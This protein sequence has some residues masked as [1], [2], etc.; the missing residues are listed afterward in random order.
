LSALEKTN[1]SAT[2][3]TT[4]AALQGLVDNITQ[5]L[6]GISSAAENNTAVTNALTP[7]I[8]SAAGVTGVSNDN[9]ALI[10]QML[11]TA[12]ING[13]AV[14][15]PAK[16]QALV[17]AVQKIRALADGIDGT[18][19]PLDN[20]DITALGLSQVIRLEADRGLFNDILDHSASSS[21]DSAA[22]I[23]N[24]ASI[25]Q[26]VVQIGL[27]D[28]PAAALTSQDFQAAGLTGVTSANL[29]RVLAAIDT[30][31]IGT[32]ARTVDTLAELQTLVNTVNWLASTAPVTMAE[33]SQGVSAAELADGLQMVVQLPS[34]AGVG[35]LLSL[36]LT[37]PNGDQRWFTHTLTAQNLVDGSVSLTVPRANVDEDGHYT[38]TSSIK[39][40]V[41]ELSTAESV[42]TFSL[43]VTAPEL[44]VTFISGNAVS[45][46][47]TAAA[48]GEFSAAERFGNVATPTAAT[49]V[50][51]PVVLQGTTTAEL[52]QSL[53]IKLNDKT[54]LATVGAGASGQPNIWTVTLPEADAKSLNHAN[55][56]DVT[57]QVSDVASN[58]TIDNQYKLFVNTAYPDVPTVDN[59]YTHGVMQGASY[60]A[61]PVLTGKA[62]KLIVGALATD[63]NNYIALADA[64][65]ITFNINGQVVTGSV[66]AL[67]TNGLTYN[68]GTRAWSLDTNQVSGFNTLPD[69]TYD[70]S[71]TV[72]AG[73]VTMVDRGS[74]ELRILS[75]PPSLNIQTLA[76]DGLINKGET[77]LDLVVSGSTDAQV[78]APVSLILNGQTYNATV[79]AG[80]GADNVFS[81]TVPKAHVMGWPDGAASVQ[82]SVT[83]RYGATT[84]LSPSLTVDTRAPGQ[85]ADGTDE[86]IAFP[87]VVLTENVNATAGI[88]AA[89]LT[90]GMQAQVTLPTGSVVGDELEIAVT[91]PN[92]T[93]RVFSHTLIQAD[94]TSGTATVTLSTSA[95]A[96]NG[97]YAVTAKTTDVAGNA[98]KASAPLSFTLDTLAPGQNAD[99]S[100]GTIP[101]TV[102]TLDEA[103]N[104]IN[105]TEL[106][107]GL[108]YQ[109]QLPTGSKAGDT[110]TFSFTGPDNTVRTHSHT[111]TAENVAAGTFILSLPNT[112]VNQDGTYTVTVRSTDTAGNAGNLATT[113]FDLTAALS[114]LRDAA[115]GNTAN[116]TTPALDVYA[117]AGITG[118]DANNLDEINSV[119]NSAAVD[120]TATNSV[121]KVQAIV[122]AYNKVLASANGTDGDATNAVSAIE[123]T[124]LGVT[125]VDSATAA[126]LSDVVD[127]K[128]SGDVDTVAELQALADAAKAAIT[129]T[130]AHGQ[131][132]PTLAQIN[133]LVAG[134][135]PGGSAVPV[136]TGD[137]AAAVQAA[138]AAANADGTAVTTQAEL[139]NIVKAAVSDYETAIAKIAAYA[140]AA[141]DVPA[142]ADYAAAGITGVTGAVGNPA[143]GNLDAINSAIKAQ[144]GVDATDGN[145]DD[146][147]AANSAAKVQAIVNAYTAILSEANG[148]A[149]D[150]NTASNP[151]A[152]QYAAI[153][154][155]IGAAATDAENLALLNSIVGAKTTTGV[156][157]IAE[158]NTLASLA[159]AIQTQAAGGTPTPL[160]TEVNLASL[161][162]TGVTTDNLRAVLNAIAAQPDSGTDTDSL[163]KLQ[164]VIGSAV[165]AYQSALTAIQNAAQNNNATDT[166]PTAAQYAALGV[167]GVTAQNL[168]AMNSALNDLDI[169]GLQANT[170][171]KV[172]TLVDAYRVILSTA[173]GAPN[174]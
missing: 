117:K 167:S 118:V 9:V 139:A 28:S 38:L 154:A 124:V 2:P 55:T 137:N 157:T 142:A 163:S 13:N 84:Q 48:T 70:V 7:A 126:L 6:G 66:A 27:G 171:A 78:G 29:S 94:I 44:V 42:S 108:Q 150:A 65:Q 127:S 136:V 133:A 57:V 95:V 173:D 93:V 164:G 120:S 88:N 73:S 32:D 56:Y 109:I 119:L 110:L 116:A 103:V 68:T 25:A 23:L 36:K 74:N 33:A 165:T 10:N 51:V 18:G 166:N 12:A 79:Q 50:A 58:T 130:A 39:R 107:N 89:E 122:D 160:L 20:A 113:T 35:D 69:G 19:A 100:A 71:V 169:T 26:R 30:A 17:D 80:Q 72:Q 98:S 90:D 22:K 41:G 62:A 77:A 105:Q 91:A 112:L 151:T 172:Q 21:V 61:K 111:V 121:A 161:G 144:A 1:G 54:Y 156:D 146:S 5:S 170:A 135:T 96:E 8:F 148:N 46:L 14:D 149:A 34:G 99:G 125:G 153:G 40:A 83:N 49:P 115:Q 159:N 15:S 152:V 47:N 141:T 138:I 158:I 45:L 63:P 24:L 162:L 143:S 140:A 16:I 87:T 131:T 92:G 168:G 64:D 85:K 86:T 123:F 59:L 3:I 145:A 52:G 129:Y 31:V 43:D 104:G 81:L 97:V 132:A 106:F 114:T 75:T 155:N 76:V 60:G 134:Q 174:N 128:N 102:L 11:D 147:A 67:R 53:Q 37:D 101:A 4:Q 82:I